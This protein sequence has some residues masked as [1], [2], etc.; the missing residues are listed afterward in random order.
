MRKIAVAV[1]GLGTMGADTHCDTLSRLE[2]F[3]LVAGCDSTPTR[4]RNVSDQYGFHGYSTIEELLAREDIELV[5]V[6][7]PSAMHREHVLQVLKAGKHCIVEKPPAMSVAEWDEMGGLARKVGRTLCCYQNARFSAP[8][9]AAMKVVD[10][11]RLGPLQSIKMMHMNYTAVMRTFGAAEYRPEWRTETRFGGGLLWDFGPHLIDRSLVLTGHAP[12]K[13][14]YAQV[15]T[16]TWSDEV[17][18]RFLVVIR[19]ANGITAHLEQDATAR[20]NMTTFMVVGSEGAFQDGVVR[21]GEVD[22]LF[23]EQVEIG[24]NE[25]DEYYVQMHEH[26]VG[27]GP[28]P[29]PWEQTRQMMAVLKAAFHS[30]STGE[31]IALA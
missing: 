24:P 27:G 19:F 2:Q 17:E 16:G 5:T 18:D 7:T 4:L 30:A 13:D 12:V 14:V 8:Q 6:A 3:D 1:M 20:V 26:L 15:S 29:V 23:E 9:V 21:T 11:G 10:Q 28:P 22:R 25:W 31:V